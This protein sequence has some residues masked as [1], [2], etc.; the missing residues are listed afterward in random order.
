MTQNET[1]VGIVFYNERHVL[2]WVDSSFIKNFI[3]NSL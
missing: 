3:E 1:V 2:Y